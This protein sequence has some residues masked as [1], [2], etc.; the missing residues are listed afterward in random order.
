MNVFSRE[1]NLKPLWSRHGSRSS[2]ADDPEVSPGR[3]S[4]FTGTQQTGCPQATHFLLYL[5]EQ[6]FV[7]DDGALAKEVRGARAAGLPVVMIHENDS[8]RDGCEFS[9]FFQTTPNDLINSG[10]Y[11]SALAIAFVDGDAHRIVSQKLFAKSL[12]AEV[13]K[14]AA[15]SSSLR[16]IRSSSAG[17]LRSLR[18]SAER[19]TDEVRSTDTCDPSIVS[20]C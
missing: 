7:D 5:N 16:G 11:S 19:R 10:L 15:R 17:S 1:P 18:N 2:K 9:R 13:L 8:S 6:T 14:H 4:R 12:G 20:S 3:L